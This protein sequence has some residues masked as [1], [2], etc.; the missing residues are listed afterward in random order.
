MNVHRLKHIFVK[1]CLR[2]L[3]KKNEFCIEI[4]AL[5]VITYISQSFVVRERTYII[6]TVHAHTRNLV[7]WIRCHV[8]VSVIVY[9]YYIALVR[10]VIVN[11]K[12][13]SQSV[14]NGVVYMSCSRISRGSHR[15]FDRILMN[16]KALAATEVC[17]PGMCLCTEA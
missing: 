15:V 4:R 9:Y 5:I 8:C 14:A 6:I 10:L 2:I 3:G 1:H 13:R 12:G 17:T 16:G 11:P 7:R